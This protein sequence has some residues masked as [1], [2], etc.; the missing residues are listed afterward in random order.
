VGFAP[1]A[2]Q[3]EALQASQ[4]GTKTGQNH[5]FQKYFFDLLHAR[6]YLIMNILR[7]RIR[8]LFSP[9]EITFVLK[10]NFICSFIKKM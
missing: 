4:N 9:F 1:T 2:N 8:S 6:N 3:I 10:V 5:G 7:N